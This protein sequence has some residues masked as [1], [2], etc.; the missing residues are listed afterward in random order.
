[1]R[2]GLFHLLAIGDNAAITLV[3][4]YLFESLFLFLLILFLE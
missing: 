3:F 2:L 1:M 4:T